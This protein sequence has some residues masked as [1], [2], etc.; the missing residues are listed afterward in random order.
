MS[1]QAIPST[2]TSMPTFKKRSAKNTLRKRQRSPE[3]RSHSSH[4]EEEEGVSEVVTKE[5]KTF[6]TPFIQSTR[7]LNKK[8]K[9]KETEGEEEQDDD[10]FSFRETYQADRSTVLKRDDATRY[11]TEYE[12]DAEALEAI[13]SAI[14]S[15]KA[16]K[17]NSSDIKKKENSKLQVGPQKAP[18]NLRVTARFDYQPDICKDYKGK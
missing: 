1:D 13:E 8:Q 3:K 16:K 6:K 17:R 5:R 12:L 7:R 14:S 4:E 15:G 10:D 11:T 18:A 9:N 2:S